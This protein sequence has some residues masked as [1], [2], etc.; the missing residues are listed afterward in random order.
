MIIEDINFCLIAAEVIL[1]KEFTGRSG[2]K[3]PTFACCL[4]QVDLCTLQ[5]A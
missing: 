3:A 2:C 5:D 4:L 1:I